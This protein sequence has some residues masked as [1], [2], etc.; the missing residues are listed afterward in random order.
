MRERPAGH[1][2]ETDW[3]ARS[4]ATNSRCE[5]VRV[6]RS[7]HGQAKFRPFKQHDIEL[8]F[9]DDGSMGVR[10]RPVIRF[11]VQSDDGR[12]SSEWR[13]WTGNKRPT[14]DA[15]LAPRSSSG[16]VKISLHK[17]GY[18][19]HGLTEP[20]RAGVRPEDRRALDRWHAQ[21]GPFP[22]MEIAYAIHFPVSE[23]RPGPALGDSTLAIPAPSDNDELAVLVVL[24][25]EP[26]SHVSMQSD[27]FQEFGRLPRATRGD[28]VLG[29]VVRESVAEQVERA[30]S[31][32]K[33]PGSTW[34]V[35]QPLS[36][37][38]NFAWQ[39]GEWPDGTHCAAEFA[40][41]HTVSKFSAGAV[42]AAFAD[43]R[44]IQ[45]FSGPKRSDM[46]FCA[47]LQIHK[48]STTTVFIDHHA[49]CD[50]SSLVTD[51]HALVSAFKRRD[52]DADWDLLEDGSYVTGLRPGSSVS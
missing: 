29:G 44:P 43:V 25:D 21:Q 52:L 24:L 35:G 30:R 48:N 19:Q 33:E 18:R 6:S 47:V 20:V 40:V 36:D 13:V 34:A 9:A 14:D 3:P 50:H 41:D 17:D 15:Y 16:R 7:R 8:F 28:L 42:G 27:N 10:N 51:L 37:E 12:R 49:R 26:G 23:L 2:P 32:L 5:L 39:F 38:E 4:R 45:E 22:G 1:L 11:A 46:D 31:I